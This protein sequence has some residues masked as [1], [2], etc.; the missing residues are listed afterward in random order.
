MTVFAALWSRVKTCQACQKWAKMRMQ[1]SC[2]PCHQE[3]KDHN[4]FRRKHERSPTMRN[5]ALRRLA[6]R[7]LAENSNNKA[8]KLLEDDISVADTAS[9]GSVDD[10]DLGLGTFIASVGDSENKR[11]VNVDV[12]D[13]CEFCDDCCENSNCDLCRTKAL[14]LR[15][16]SPCVTQN[17]R[18]RFYTPCQVRRHNHIGSAWLV[19][20]DTIY[21]AT[22]YL[23]RHPGGVESILKKAGGAQDCSRDL[24]FHSAQGKRMFTKYEIGKVRACGCSGTS[25]SK[26]PNGQWWFLW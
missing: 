15:L 21:D 23:S 2:R 13:A 6:E 25:R 16:C 18:E 3:S 11:H 24:Q 1:P 9:V 12:C 7:R 26:V 22:P 8:E 17:N 14:S 10:I 20:G 4:L 5:A 19:A